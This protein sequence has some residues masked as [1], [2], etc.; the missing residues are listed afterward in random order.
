MPP[1]TIL[2][3]SAAEFIH[4]SF[5]GDDLVKV[6]P[7]TVTEN[8]GVDDYRLQPAPDQEI[9][10][11]LQKEC[12]NA[13]HVIAILSS[14]ALSGLPNQILRLIKASSVSP[15]LVM[16]DTASIG[17]GTGFLVEKAARLAQEGS[18]WTVIEQAIRE[19][20]SSLYTT[21]ILPDI[22]PL[23]PVGLVDQAQANAA[24]I[25]GIQ[26]I[27]SMEEGLPTPLG[28]VRS[29]RAA[30][31]YLVEF[32]DEFER[33]HLIAIVH[34]G[35]ADSN[36]LQVIKDHLAEFFPGTVLQQFPT[37]AAWKTIFGSH[38]YG[39]VIISNENNR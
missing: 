2:T 14:G 21:A 3:D 11:L 29:R 28:K 19:D 18:A 6:I 4:K 33:F 8:P 16:I 35:N 15:L 17:L 31:E 37:N 25:L 10:A 38:S 1:V 30:Y 39:M 36:D 5:A 27:F 9:Q 32:I 13:G 7:L 23:V 12:Q 22:H 24:S 20:C 26:S 34:E